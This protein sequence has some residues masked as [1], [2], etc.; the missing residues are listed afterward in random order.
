MPN[1][2]FAFFGKRIPQVFH[3]HLTAVTDQ[4]VA[5]RKKE[6]GKDVKYS[7]RKAGQQYQKKHACKSNWFVD[8]FCRPNQRK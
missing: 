3:N 1:F 2:F 5:N 8:Y 6:I 7:Q 4:V